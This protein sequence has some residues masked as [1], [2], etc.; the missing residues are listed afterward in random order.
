MERLKIVNYYREAR[1]KKIWVTDKWPEEQQLWVKDWGST[2]DDAEKF[3]AGWTKY[4]RLKTGKWHKTE[5]LAFHTNKKDL[6]PIHIS[7]KEWDSVIS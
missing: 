2:L 6:F 7:W 3:F 4:K 5:L 1:G